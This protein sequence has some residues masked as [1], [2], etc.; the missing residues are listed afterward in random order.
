MGHIF[1][2]VLCSGTIL[3]VTAFAL[4][5]PSIRSSQPEAEQALLAH[6]L[7]DRTVP[8]QLDRHHRSTADRR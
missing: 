2:C 4:A 8:Q 6:L 5:A 3:L 7:Q 1:L